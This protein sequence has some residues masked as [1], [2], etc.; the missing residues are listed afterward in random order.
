VIG[1]DLDLMLD[2][3]VSGG[4][5]LLDRL[6]MSVA[7]VDVFEVNEAFASVPMSFARVHG[8]DEDRLNPSGG[9]IAIG[10]PAGATGI[11]LIATALAELER[12]DGTLAMVAICASASTTCLLLERLG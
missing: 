6:G 7:D 2:G 10:H 5:I 9:A 11:R 4:R 1:G 3:P 8:V 12:R